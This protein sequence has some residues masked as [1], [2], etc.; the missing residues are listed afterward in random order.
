MDEQST[1]NG[2]DLSNSVCKIN[3]NQGRFCKCLLDVDWSNDLIVRYR[4]YF[5]CNNRVDA[6]IKNAYD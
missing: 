5:L 6:L 3:S 4:T 2:F 1:V